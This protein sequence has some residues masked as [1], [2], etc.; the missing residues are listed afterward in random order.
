MVATGDQGRPRRRAKRGGVELGVTQ[1]RLGNAVQVR[2]GND[3]AE[4]AGDTVA[5]VIGHDEEHVGR[6]LGR[7][8]TGRPPGLRIRGHFFDHATERRWRRGKLL[9]IDGGSGIGRA[10]G[11]R[12]HLR[13]SDRG[14][15]RKSCDQK[16]GKRISN[17]GRTGPMF[18]S[19][20]RK[21]HSV[22][23]LW[24]SSALRRATRPRGGPQPSA[25]PRL[26]YRMPDILSYSA[27]RGYWQNLQRRGQCFRTGLG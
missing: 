6:A 17:R 7:Y 22:P 3:T 19:G 26:A 1:A 24:H 5:L 12:D 8:D 23:H 2:R 18:P 15:C 4:G 9:P 13:A 10:Q 21:L 14:E 27:V 16:Y 11:A 25:A 20:S